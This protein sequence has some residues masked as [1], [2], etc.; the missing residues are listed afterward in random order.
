M[1]PSPRRAFS[2][3]ELLV[4]IAIIAVL[5]SLLLPAIAKAREA[6]RQ[7]KCLSNQRQIGTA[8]VS[9]ANA[10]REFTPREAGTSENARP[11]EVPACRGSEFNLAWA[12]NLRPFLDGRAESS[13]PSAGLADQ[14]RNAPYYIDP[15]RPKDPH[16]IHYVV[17]GLRFTAPNTVSS[18]SKGPTQ[19]SRYLRPSQTMYMTCFVDDPS[20]LR[21]GSFYAPGN[22]EL[23]IA[24]FYDMW[25]ISNVNGIGG[26]T[27]ETA[28]RIA[29]NRH[30]RGAN[31]MFLDGHA[32]IRSAAELTTV[33][34][35]D[36]GDYR[37][38]GR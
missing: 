5:I 26:T 14:Y 23:N 32:L 17:N 1:S 22:S 31:A 15:S 30:G 33:A 11:P 37:A 12:F 27:P 10:Y 4:V 35:W 21:W 9:Y 36:D 3:I 16:N 34:S 25:R 19:L 18:I 6:G 2:L 20:G 7:V 28:Q 29:V 8:L 38:Y 13:T 24:I